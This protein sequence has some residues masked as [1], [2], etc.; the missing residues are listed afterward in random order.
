MK[1]VSYFS[2]YKIILQ[3][4]K[5]LDEL[6]NLGIARWEFYVFEVVL[7]GCCPE[8][9]WQDRSCTEWELARREL[10]HTCGMMAN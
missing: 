8:E 1:N 7:G 3:I 6:S 9:S 10:P 5:C 4:R 2:V